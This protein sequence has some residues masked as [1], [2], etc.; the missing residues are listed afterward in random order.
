MQKQTADIK[1]GKKSLYGHVSGLPEPSSGSLQERKDDDKDT[2]RDI[3]TELGLSPMNISDTQRIGKIDSK[4]PRL[5]CVTCADKS[6]KFDL[7]RSAK[8]LRNSEKYKHCFINPDMTYAEREKNRK[9]RSEVKE[10]RQQ[11]LDVIIRNGKV[12][13]RR[14]AASS[15]VGQNFRQGF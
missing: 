3:V 9:L 8:E 14:D 1:S 13:L 11:G 10:K 7:L 5:L 2:V 15:G 12:V 4:K 6:S